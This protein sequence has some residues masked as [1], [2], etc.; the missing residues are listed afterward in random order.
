MVQKNA[1]NNDENTKIIRSINN[2]SYFNGSNI[3]SKQKGNEKI[4]EEN[5]NSNNKNKYENPN[6]KHNIVIN[7]IK[8]KEEGYRRSDTNINCNLGEHNFI[9]INISRGISFI[10]NN[11]NNDGE[12]IESTT[13]KM[14]LEKGNLDDVTKGNKNL[15]SHYYKN[16]L[17]DK[18]SKN[19]SNY[20]NPLITSVFIPTFDMNKYS[21]EM[22]NAINS[23]RTNPE[24]FIKHIDY[25]INNN[26][27]QTEEGIFL[28]SFE[29][30][31]KIKL[32]DNYMEMFNKAK[33]ILKEKMNSKKELSKLSKLV[34]NDDLEIILDET[35]YNESDNNENEFEEEDEQEND[36]KNI[37]FRLNKIYDDDTCL[38]DEEIEEDYDKSNSKGNLKIID[39]DNNVEDI[40]TREKDN[41]KKYNSNIIINNNYENNNNNYKIFVNNNDININY[42][43]KNKYK[44]R[45]KVKK[46][47]NINSI[48]DLNDDKI[49]NLIFQKRKLIKRQYPQNIFKM[50]VIKDIK[51]SIL[52]QIISEEFFKE[53]NNNKLKDIIFNSNFKYFAVSWTNEINRNFISISCFA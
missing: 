5:N 4:E 20:N 42:N 35:H 11:N 33:E 26:I 41:D 43:K 51:I 19:Q 30:D 53:N 45:T 28:I 16:R 15:F 34:Y 25:L 12:K 40:Q 39:L 14:I 6:N 52:I 22:L 48:L 24:L 49:A 18:A 36:I 32:T 21:D 27:N 37:P 47:R 8:K 2:S 9:F 46:K 23:I 38:I 44:K 17:A 13:P 7:K 3:I 31:E 29:V 10:H 1:N 50:S